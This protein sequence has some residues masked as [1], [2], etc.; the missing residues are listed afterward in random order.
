MHETEDVYY[1]YLVTILYSRAPTTIIFFYLASSCNAESHVVSYSPISTP[2]EL[3][4]AS[5]CIR[6]I[7]VVVFFSVRV[8]QNFSTFVILFFSS[9]R[10]FFFFFYLSF[11]Y[12]MLQ[13]SHSW[14][15]QSFIFF[16]HLTYNHYFCTHWILNTRT[17][18]L[19]IC[20]YIYSLVIIIRTLLA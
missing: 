2:R 17:V 1:N 5:Q 8:D 11:I 9:S 14:Q 3:L 10:F 7:L 13:L 19:L 18:D 6:T 15:D 12:I 16:D 20:H 4:L